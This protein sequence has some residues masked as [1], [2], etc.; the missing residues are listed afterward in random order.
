MKFV[1]WVKTGKRIF[2]C[3]LVF[4]LIAGMSVNF[5]YAGEADFTG[6]G[7][8]TYASDEELV[9]D[10]IKYDI[11]GTDVARVSTGQDTGLSGVVVIP[12][13]I[14]DGND[15]YSVVSIHEDAFRG[16]N[17]ITF[18]EIPDS[19]TSIQNNAFVGCSNLKEVKLST[20]LQMIGMN[21]F[22][23][24]QSLR[25]IEIPDHVTRIWWGAFFNCSSLEE[26]KLSINLEKIMNSTFYNC[27]SLKVIE[28][29]DSVTSI[30][31]SAFY[32]CSNLEEVK[33]PT[34]L[35][36]MERSAF[37]QCSSLKVI[38]IPDSVTSIEDFTFQGCSNLETVKLPTNLETIKDNAFTQCNSLRMIEIPDSVTSIN[39]SAFGWCSNLEEIKLS[40]S[41]Q[42]IGRNVFRQ[43]ENLRVIEI[44]NSVTSVGE[45]AFFECR[46]LE[47]AQLSENLQTIEKQAFFGCQNLA[48]IE[49]PDSVTSI[50]ESAFLGCS[51]LEEIKLSENLQTIEH[52]AF[53]NCQSLRMIKI[54]D[55]V[56]SVGSDAFSGCMSLEEIK[57]SANL[58]GIGERVFLGCQNLDIIEIP[59]HIVTAPYAF[60]YAASLETAKIS[61]QLVI[62]N[63]F[64]ECRQLE[65]LQIKVT[66]KDGNSIIP[67]E[68]ASGMSGFSYT[69]PPLNRKLE[70]WTEDGSAKLTGD[71]LKAAQK[72]YMAVEDGDTSDNLWYGWEVVPAY[73]VTLAVNKDGKPWTDHGRILKLTKDNG[74]SFVDNLSSVL[75]G[76]YQI[77]DF[78]ENADGINTG[79]TVEVNGSNVTSSPV[80]Y[81]TVTFYD[82][83]D[84]PYGTDTVQKPQIALSGTNAAVPAEPQKSGYRF[85]GWKNDENGQTPFDFSAK[86]TNT[87]DIY[88]GWMK[89]PAKRQH[90]ITAFAGEGGS[91][92]PS[93]SVIVEDGLN[94]EFSIVPDEGV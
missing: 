9:V 43:C 20:N 45:G 89:N 85:D 81:Y 37:G 26:V 17:N 15:S 79:V 24:C 59:N 74:S 90:T 6:D 11:T 25:R 60:M 8:D 29:P 94:Q 93:G 35:Q 4:V 83:A 5:L 38:E 77:V 32:G 61:D 75:D 73:E 39:D 49:I 1:Q 54:P 84:N 7:V 48:M 68:N 41:L 47:K 10:G 12:A 46:S 28:I 71:A 40:A 53:V 2:C 87:T 64:R 44:P 78:T 36:M 42:T 22:S 57:F 31:E 3:L 52:D 23:D 19:V 65:T 92:S 56:T 16:C 86:I 66:M 18:I 72:A 88:A 34:N 58:S 21:A 80:N 76:T 27:S 55:S 14:S 30:E 69:G 67:I 62:D 91:I 70:F 33:L 51:N 13:S 63:T 50:E 82:G